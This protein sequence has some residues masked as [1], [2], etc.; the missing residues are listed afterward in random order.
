MRHR[1]DRH[2]FTLVE[3]L[4]VIAII[5]TLV[6]LLLPAV[7]AARESARRSG[8]QNNLKQLGLSANP[9][10]AIDATSNDYQRVCYQACNGPQW[11][12]TNGDCTSYDSWCFIGF[13][14]KHTDQLTGNG[15]GGGWVPGMFSG[16]GGS[17]ISFSKVPDGLSN[18]IMLG[19][20]R[21]EVAWPHMYQTN[22]QAMPT[23]LKINSPRMT[24]SSSDYQQNMGA[25][26]H[27][28]GG[29]AF[30]MGDGAV[31]FLSENIDFYLYNL[32]GNRGDGI[33]ARLP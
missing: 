10:R 33:S 14:N 20:Q 13:W 16:R 27:H 4:V 17:Q 29:A 23:L 26:S 22:N 30:C 21:G 11:S 1:S 25:A 2:G 7:Q 32:L 6:G 18:T 3:L 8:C 31:V 9:W 15:P 12:D 5:G 19:E 24:K 28:A